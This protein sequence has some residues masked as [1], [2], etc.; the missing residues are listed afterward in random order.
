[1]KRIPWL[2]GNS[3][4]R[5]CVHWQRR[6]Y[7]NPPHYTQL[8]YIGNDPTPVVPLSFA[9]VHHL[10]TEMQL[11]DIMALVWRVQ[12]WTIAGTLGASSSYNMA[13]DE[14]GFN[15]SLIWNSVVQRAYWDIASAGTFIP[16]IVDD[17]Q[18]LFGAAA[19]DQLRPF[20]DAPRQYP[21]LYLSDQMSVDSGFDALIN[22]TPATP[23]CVFTNTGS[24]PF[25][26]VTFPITSVGVGLTSNEDADG[27]VTSAYDRTNHKLSALDIG[28]SIEF[29]TLGGF[30]SKTG[31][32]LQPDGFLT[33][34]QQNPR[35]SG[36]VDHIEFYFHTGETDTTIFTPSEVKISIVPDALTIKLGSLTFKRAMTFVANDLHSNVNVAD[37]AATAALTLTATKFFPFQN[38]LGQPVYDT[39]TG[40]QINDPFS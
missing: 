25:G 14:S 22:V 23:S 35:F 9:G 6:F 18:K 17:E 10:N 40:A 37:F 15:Y 4:Q 13:A 16:K 12:E 24:P 28:L 27:P 19:P 29:S 36:S 3:L 33:A 5:D 11:D 32:P 39:A 34:N 2:G 26:P 21:D 38:R 8:L 1:M 30:N 7:K 31:A 20:V